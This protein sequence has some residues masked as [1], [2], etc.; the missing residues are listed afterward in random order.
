MAVG[1]ACTNALKHGSPRGELDEVRAKCMCCEQTVI[2]EISDNGH[3]FDP[4]LVVPPAPEDFR[5][6]GRGL[7]VMRGLMDA[8]EFSFGRGTT[9]R[10]VKHSSITTE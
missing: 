9:V 4:D 2:V 7:M 1:E 6:N 5:E 10:L 8:V 3:G